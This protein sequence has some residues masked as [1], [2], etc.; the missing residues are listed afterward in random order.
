MNHVHR[1]RCGPPSR[2]TSTAAAASL[3]RSATPGLT[4]AAVSVGRLVLRVVVV[5]VSPPETSKGVAEL[6]DR[7][8]A[9]ERRLGQMDDRLAKSL[10][11]ILASQVER[12]GAERSGVEQSGVELSGAEQSRSEQSGAEQSGAERGGA[13]WS[14]AKRSGAGAP[15]VLRPY[16]S[17]G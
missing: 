9:I 12:S 13:E 15:R 8:A 3:T 16:L 4:R 11:A 2:F 6:R 14:V 5:V 1:V 10:D 17:Q 7:S